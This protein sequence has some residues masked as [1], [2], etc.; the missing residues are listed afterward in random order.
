MEI[1][2]VSHIGLDDRGNVTGLDPF[3]GTTLTTGKY[4]TSLL[5]FVSSTYNEY[6]R[7]AEL[8]GYESPSIKAQL[9]IIKER[10]D[11]NSTG[12][13]RPV[14][15]IGSEWFPYEYHPKPKSETSGKKMKGE[16]N[17]DA[18]LRQIQKRYGDESITEEE[19]HAELV[20]LYQKNL[21]R[22]TLT[23]DQRE[24]IISLNESFKFFTEE[25]MNDLW[26]RFRLSRPQ[27]LSLN[28]ESGMNSLFR[29]FA[30]EKKKKKKTRS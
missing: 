1:V 30:K 20:D 14:E 16:T 21:S 29:E 4:F 9:D 26:Y 11:K 6:L 2:D 5:P 28:S 12:I 25:E 3:S 23:N 10:R 7:A 13:R 18:A 8:Y 15:E 22:L 27:S 24:L 17:F 19:Y